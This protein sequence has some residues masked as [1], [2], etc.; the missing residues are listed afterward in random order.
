MTILTLDC[1]TIPLVSDEIRAEV[2]DSI[3]VP[4]SYSKPETIANWEAQV[5][6][7][8]VDAELARGGIGLMLFRIFN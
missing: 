1:E 5:K 4:G 6:P 8:L 7:G 2:S 3:K